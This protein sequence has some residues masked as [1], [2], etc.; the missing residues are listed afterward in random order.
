MK[1]LFSIILLSVISNN[2][3][4]Q[5]MED[6]VAQVKDKVIEWRRHIHQN[7]ELSFHETQ[8]ADYVAAILKSFGNIEVLRPAKTTVLGILK[9][10]LQGKTVAFRADMDALPVPE[11]TELPYASQVPGISHACGHDAHSAMLLGTASVLSKMRK[12]L[13]GTVYFIFQ[14]AEEQDPGGALDIINSGVLK[15]VNAIFGMHVLPNFPEGHVGI[16]PKGAASTSADGFYL[17]IQGKGSHGS[18]PHLGVDP[19][20]TG[21]QI[22][23]ALQ[24]IVS[25]N[26]PPGEMAVVT[27]GKF[28]SGNAYNVI[29]DKA[30]LAATVRTVTETSRNLIEQRIRDIIENITKSNGA[31]YK[32]DYFRSYPAIQND[33]AL[34]DFVRASAGKAVGAAKVFE[35][36]SMTASEDF[37]YYHKLAPVCFINLGV[38]PGV[39]NHNPKFN[40]DESAL[41]NGVRVEV[42]IILDFLRQKQ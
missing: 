15:G 1:N 33:S 42:Q 17:T 13:R 37:S 29:P 14:H 22:V 7:P 6:A 41:A 23:T 31:T 12:D 21:A 34:V 16:L 36:P 24:T 35:A 4:A 38:G 9:G 2:L 27:I 28:Q 8:T 32:L 5:K 20:V 18:M 11:E 30:E 26:I 40:P 25:R 10:A 39:A 3:T 19:V